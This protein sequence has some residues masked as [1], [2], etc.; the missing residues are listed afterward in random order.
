MYAG[1]FGA[2]FDWIFERMAVEFLQAK[3]DLADFLKNVIDTCVLLDY[4]Q[5]NKL[6]VQAN[7]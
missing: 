1:L 2:L 3:V 5:R 7:S 6:I 4:G